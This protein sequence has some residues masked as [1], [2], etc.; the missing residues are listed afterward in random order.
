MRA[1]KINQ[2]QA[3]AILNMRLRQLRRLE[4][5]GIE[6][7]NAALTKERAGLQKLLKDEKRRWR[8]VADEIADIKKRF[9]AKTV[10]GRRRTTIGTPPTAVVVPLDAM[11]EREPITVLCSEKGWIRAVKGHV[12]DFAQVRYKEGDRGRFALHAQTTDKVLV[13]ATNGRF[14]TLGCDKLPGGR[15][16]GE[17]L[18]LMIELGN[19][20]DAVALFVHVPGRRLLVASDDGRG[21]VVAEDGVIARTRN[22]KQVLN[23]APGEEATACAAVGARDDTVAVLGGAR[24]L[25]LF[26][27]DELPVMTRGRGVI[28]QR[29][30]QGRLADVKTFKFGEGLTWRSGTRLRTE[31]AIE[32]WLGRRAQAGRLPPKG[33]TRANRF[34]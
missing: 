5:V 21:F 28:L 14:Y 22:G 6:R 9:G 12:A 23:L 25:L 31:T 18:R 15:G 34:A 4:E 3:E 7:E 19:G 16:H 1:F 30:A 8:L 11:I 27:L 13:F 26:K 17:P 24:R 2:A 32:P 20:H 33:F 29:Y 10:L